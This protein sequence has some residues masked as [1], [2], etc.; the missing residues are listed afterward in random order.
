MK[1]ADV[2]KTEY[3]EQY[4]QYRWIGQMQVVVLSLYGVV[5]SFA[6]RAFRPQASS[7]IDYRWPAGIMIALGLLG[8]FVGYGLFRSRTMQRRTAWYLTDLLI[9]MARAVED[10]SSE[11]DSALRFRGLCSTRTRFKLWNTMNVV[12]LITL[13]CGEAFT[14][15]GV[16]AFLVIGMILNLSQAAWIGVLC[17][18]SLFALT[19]W[20]VQKLIMDK[21]T[22]NMNIH[23]KKIEQFQ[24][25]E[26]MREDFGL[27]KRKEVE[28]KESGPA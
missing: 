24:T 19:P 4:N 14:L 13:Y 10:A 8:L 11:K 18:F 25:L 20:L 28:K 5:S 15:T 23:Y 6:M 21:E 27:P 1:Y 16:L 2:L 17:I 9:Q 7:P 3:K 26:Q 22:K 12:I